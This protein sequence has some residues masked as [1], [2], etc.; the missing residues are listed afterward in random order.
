MMISSLL[1]PFCVLTG[2]G[3]EVRCRSAGLSRAGTTCGVGVERCVDCCNTGAA[4]VMEAG[5][6]SDSTEGEG[7]GDLSLILLRGD[8]LGSR[9][10]IPMLC[11]SA[12]YRLSEAA[13]IQK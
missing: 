8:G 9:G 12:M 4:A 3:L 2:A 11:R 7:E 13:P 10:M 1:R 5:L 6:G